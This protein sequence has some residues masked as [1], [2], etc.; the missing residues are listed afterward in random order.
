MGFRP[1]VS[2]V[3][4]PPRSGPVGGHGD[5]TGYMKSDG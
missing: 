5:L 1:L 3:T 2:G 4:I